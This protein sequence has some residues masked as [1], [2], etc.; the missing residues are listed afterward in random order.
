[1]LRALPIITKSP[2]AQRSAKA[3]GP[4]VP[5]PEAAS[6]P[7]PSRWD[8]PF[9]R[10]MT[11]AVIDRIL[12]C[13]PFCDVDE[14]KFPRTLSLRNILKNDSA[15]RTY[16]PGEVIVRDGDYGTS[17]FMILDGAV[18]VVLSP[19]LPA[20]VLGRRKPQ[21]RGW[22]GSLAQLWRTSGIPEVRHSVGAVAEL[23][24]PHDGESQES[25]SRG[26]AEAND[27]ESSSPERV[28]LA[29][30]P[31]ILRKH[32]TARMAVHNGKA[33]GGRLFGEIGALARV[34]RSATVFAETGA[35]L[36]EIRWQ[37]LRD[38][39]RSAPG[40]KEHVERTFRTN[41]LN[42]ALRTNPLFDAGHLGDE[43]LQAIADH[44]TFE[45][46][47]QFDWHTS[48]KK[49]ADQDMA[50]RLAQEPIIGSEGHYANGVVFILSGFA[51]I[52][53]RLGSSEQTT[54]Y[55]GAGQ[56]SGL[57]EVFHNWVNRDATVPLQHTLRAVG[58][59]TTLFVPARALE[60]H[61]FPTLPPEARPEPI[62]STSD[63]SSQG[64]SLVRERKAA[65]TISVDMLEFLVEER[66]INGTQ[67]MMIDMDR[68]TRCDDCVRACA[69]THNGNP[70]FVRHGPQHDHYMFANACMHCADPVCMIGCPTGAIHRVAAGG[71]VVI[72]D[73]TCIGCQ[74]CANNCPYSN[75]RMVPIRDPAGSLLID[76]KQ[77]PI[78][79]ATKCDLCVDQ[80][81][82]PA[83]QAACP[84]DALIRIDTTHT[85]PLA[86]WMKR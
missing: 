12:A 40:I 80:L 10:D 71:E 53:R 50:Q 41:M 86:A 70:R 29:D 7:R 11:Q 47:G 57:A 5:A 3:A 32:K 60:E 67:T 19:S 39:M 22:L 8:E 44:G 31:A 15:L 64:A 52:S 75:I 18:R 14:N 42:V 68:C 2:A 77:L 59:V 35:E 38:I 24:L 62:V 69:S 51:R 84:H 9:S 49:S 37:G 63:S 26:T 76:G 78:L 27:A 33:E 20:N 54:G 83:C 45:M 48:F 46:H 66:V 23:A 16:E 25:G 74:Q 17:A 36:I 4:A 55:V 81:G 82:G 43:G 34:P 21:R 58:Y 30:L 65:E 79:K 85:D 13:E 1:M 73:P 6:I 72:N 56:L 28:V 61:V